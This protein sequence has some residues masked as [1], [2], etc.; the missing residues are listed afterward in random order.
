MLSPLPSSTSSKLIEAPLSA[1]F[2]DA[3][4][5]AG[6]PDPLKVYF[7]DDSALNIKGAHSLKWGHSVLFDEHGEQQE[8]LGGL[9]KLDTGEKEGKVSV[10]TS[11]NG[12]N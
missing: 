4:T 11:M 2:N 8:K 7:V 1:Y 12:E 5:A 9:E 10:V 6:Q 3:L